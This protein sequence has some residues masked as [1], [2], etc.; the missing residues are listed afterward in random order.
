MV[1]F[2]NTPKKPLSGESS[3]SKIFSPSGAV[4]DKNP[5]WAWAVIFVTS[6][7]AR[8]DV[9]DFLTSGN[10]CF[11]SPSFP[12]HVT[13]KGRALGTRMVPSVSV[14]HAY[15]GENVTALVLLTFIDN[16]K[17]RRNLK[18]Y[19]LEVTKFGN[20]LVNIALQSLKAWKLKFNG[21]FWWPKNQISHDSY[22]V[23]NVKNCL[24]KFG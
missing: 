9:R 21:G 23:K 17:K 20:I 12:Y 3:G 14:E 18:T 10:G 7:H 15:L 11:Q 8:Q 1:H 6:A 13:K 16:V 4:R 2:Q 22:F 24:I 5:L 19:S